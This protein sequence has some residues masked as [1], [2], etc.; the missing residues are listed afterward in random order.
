MQPRHGVRRDAAHE[1]VSDHKIR[2]HLERRHERGE[3]TEIIAVVRIAHD[4]VA[5]PGSTDSALEGASIP[6]LRH[7]DHPR[8][9]LSGDLDRTVR[10]AVIGHHD[11]ASERGLLEIAMRLLDAD[12]ERLFLIEAWNQDGQGQLAESFS[13]VSRLG[14]GQDRCQNG[15]GAPVQVRHICIEVVR[16]LQ[17]FARPSHCGAD[18][19][20]RA[21][22]ISAASRSG[23]GRADR[24]SA[25]DGE[26]EG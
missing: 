2:S 17:R 3:I 15:V 20:S 11:L 23:V 14:N 19:R 21:P 25:G 5:A 9:Q 18:Q 12:S 22:S 13:F 4:D 26:A 7:R 16:T 10:T 24:G 6:T 8:T 1:T